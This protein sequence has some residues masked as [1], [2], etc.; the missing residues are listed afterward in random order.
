MGALPKENRRMACV[1]ILRG[2]I[3]LCE[4]RGG[5]EKPC[6]V[7]IESSTYKQSFNGKKIPKEDSVTI[8]R[9]AQ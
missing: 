5:D 9:F 4:S 6:R 3:C 8:T 7:H 2:C 1:Q